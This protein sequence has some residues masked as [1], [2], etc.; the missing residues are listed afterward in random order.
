MAY[1]AS[2]SP[3]RPEHPHALGSAPS[4]PDCSRIDDASF[5]ST[6]VDVSFAS[7]S[8]SS[9]PATP[10]E[11]ESF[12][13]HQGDAMDISPMPPRTFT[14]PSQPGTS[15]AASRPRSKTLGGLNFTRPTSAEARPF[16]RELS[17]TRS[18]SKSPPKAPVTIRNIK[19]SPE[20]SPVGS[21]FA[22]PS[23]SSKPLSARQRAGLPTTWL[24]PK[25]AATTRSS[26]RSP[27][28]IFAKPAPIFDSSPEKSQCSDVMDLDSSPRKSGSS[29]P[30]ITS[31]PPRPEPASDNDDLGELFFESASPCAAPIL[32]KKR[33]SQD[34]LEN[35]ENRAIP[36]GQRRSREG[37]PQNSAR[38][39][40]FSAAPGRSML[41]K[42]QDAMESKVPDD[43]EDEVP[44]ANGLPGCRDSE[45]HGKILPC[46]KVKED[47]IV[48][49]TPETL[50]SLLRG[51]YDDHL[52]AFHIVDCRFDYE[53]E[54]GHI[55]GATNFTTPE[56]AA[57]YFLDQLSVPPPSSSGEPSPDGDLKTVL[58]F[59]CEFSAKRG[60]TFAKHLRAQDRKRCHEAY[61]RVHYPEVYILQGGYKGFWESHPHRCGGYTEMDDPNH[62]EARRE[63]IDTMRKWERTRSYT[64]GERSAAVA[65]LGNNKAASASAPE[66]LAQRTTSGESVSS[67]GKVTGGLP[68]RRAAALST[69]V[70]HHE[71]DT[72]FGNADS[73]CSFTGG[74]GDSPC[75]ANMLAKKNTASTIRAVPGRR[76]PLGR[77][78]TMG[79]L[80]FSL[81][82]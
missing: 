30:F 81:K 42:L 67:L 44:V 26:K 64:Y 8:V 19:A 72:S 49:I 20:A 52:K 69:L 46:F 22:D 5:L 68:P 82:A 54:G 55:D 34:S 74:V 47:G 35:Q 51:E 36:S 25:A 43:D 59:H 29:R 21:L 41:A 57:D 40:P 2:S 63:K 3:E 27:G 78:S 13:L 10:T 50:E 18:S 60:P 16:G 75:P 28:N 33:R 17:N 11:D 14:R 66:A 7:I 73:D 76:A 15:S 12:T 77:A 80:V 61:P 1:Y 45:T 9:Q 37:S 70:E 6:D 56:E 65:A 4:S 79:P 38:A 39:A 32:N 53:F 71:A 23:P 24:N 48:R 31:S 58:V 62:V